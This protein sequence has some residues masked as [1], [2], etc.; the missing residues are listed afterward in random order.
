MDELHIRTFFCFF[1]N[2]IFVSREFLARQRSL[3]E[4]SQLMS[5]K[6]QVNVISDLFL[7]HIGLVCGILGTTYLHCTSWKIMYLKLSLCG[8]TTCYSQLSSKLTPA[9][10]KVPAQHFLPKLFLFGQKSYFLARKFKSFK[11]HF[12]K[13]SQKKFEFRCENV[14]TLGKEFPILARKFKV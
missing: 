8:W 14:S 5:K 1:E 4:N 3:R 6:K 9:K 13:K 11:K 2:S 10:I 12:P 7:N